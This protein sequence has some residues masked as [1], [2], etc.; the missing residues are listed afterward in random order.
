[1]EGTSIEQVDFQVQLQQRT[2]Y[3]RA[4]PTDLPVEIVPKPHV[5]VLPLLFVHLNGWVAVMDDNGLTD[6]AQ[7]NRV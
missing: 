1:M 3:R 4:L 5:G 7:E 2:T 6:I